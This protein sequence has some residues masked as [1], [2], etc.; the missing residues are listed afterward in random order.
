MLRFCPSD[1]L[2]YGFPVRLRR[3]RLFSDAQPDLPWYSPLAVA[4]FGS[5]HQGGRRASP[6]ELVIVFSA[7]SILLRHGRVNTGEAQ[8]E[9]EVKVEKSFVTLSF[10]LRRAKR[11]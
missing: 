4:V 6:N 3:N 1:S 10:V 8:D 7:C 5:L 11:R 2:M 9:V